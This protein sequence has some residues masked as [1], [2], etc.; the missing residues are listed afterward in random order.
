MG[1]IRDAIYGFI[2][3]TS[4]ELKIINS[5]LLQR[6]RRIK[7]L[8]CAYLVYPCAVHT[9]FEH[10]LGVFYISSIM[11]DK[12]LKGSDKD[13]NKR[14]VKLAAL[15]HDVGHGPFSHV[16]E[17]ILEMFSDAD[18]GKVKEKIHERITARLIETD[19]GIKNILGDKVGQIVG[20]LTGKRIDI[21]LMKEIISGPIDADK[22]DYLLRDSY[23]CGVKYGIYDYQRLINTIDSYS[24]HG[25]DYI[26]FKEGGI[27]AL[28]QFI[29]AK[30]YITQTVYRHKV[31]LI[32]DEMIIRAYPKTS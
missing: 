17:S 28:E 26:Q 12:L 22:Q 25:D 11:A 14:I 21:S 9:R 29:L 6:L 32:T 20:L 27:H 13:E 10:S 23:F 30:Y 2:E 24:D 16:S 18:S 8:A 31:R 5:S 4:E 3:P 15:L 1:E 7:Q 19:K